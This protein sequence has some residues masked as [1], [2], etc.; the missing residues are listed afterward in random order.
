M[1][2]LPMAPTEAEGTVLARDPQARLGDLLADIE[3][4]HAELE[5]LEARLAQIEDRRGE[6]EPGD[7]RAE[8]AERAEA[9]AHRIA[10]ELLRRGRTQ[11][12]AAP[13]RTGTGA[14]SP[15]ARLVVVDDARAD[16]GATQVAPVSGPDHTAATLDVRVGPALVVAPATTGA[17][18]D[19]DGLPPGP[20]VE[21]GSA[22]EVPMAPSPQRQPTA[23][24]PGRLRRWARPAE[25]CVHL[26][27]LVALIAVALGA[28]R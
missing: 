9:L 13:A 14:V 12:A 21:L 24:E 19:T 15:A 8:R 28:F 22:S 11:L 20:V 26:V 25:I 7:E 27:I 2:A 23:V 4:L 3:A 17:Q 10:D 16:R 5:E 18:V 1:T 6:D